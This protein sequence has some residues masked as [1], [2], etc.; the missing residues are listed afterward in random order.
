VAVRGGNPP[1]RRD[2]RLQP[3]SRAGV[4]PAP[5]GIGV[6]SRV[7]ITGGGVIQGPDWIINSNGFFQYDAPL[8]PAAGTLVWSSAPAPGTDSAGNPYPGTTPIS[9]F[10]TANGQTFESNEATLLRSGTDGVHSFTGLIMSPGTYSG[11]VCQIVNTSAVGSL[12]MAAQAVS[13]VA[14]GVANVIP[15]NSAAGFVWVINVSGSL[16]YPL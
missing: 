8:P 16:W 14:M 10:I 11:H 5:T 7:V 1:Q 4:G 13:N 9:Q 3:V 6:F 2:Q 12:T 15:A